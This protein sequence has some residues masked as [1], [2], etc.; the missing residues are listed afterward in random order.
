MAVPKIGPEIKLAAIA[1]LTTVSLS[2]ILL[3]FAGF[4]RN[5][6][7]ANAARFGSF[8]SSGY[9]QTSGARCNQSS[10][11]MTISLFAI[12]LLHSKARLVRISD[13]N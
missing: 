11:G 5:A 1:S 6:R 13:A 2:F 9:S 3:E 4:H 8:S 10:R 12:S 7:A